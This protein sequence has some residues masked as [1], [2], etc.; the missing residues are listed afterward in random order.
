MEQLQEKKVKKKGKTGICKRIIVKS[1]V[2]RGVPW[3]VLYY[4]TYL[5]LSN[6]VSC[7]LVHECGMSIL[8]VGFVA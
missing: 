1:Y 5:F 2:A 3:A 6:M 7:Y 8:K 4:H